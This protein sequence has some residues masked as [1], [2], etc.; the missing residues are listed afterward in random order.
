MAPL[1]QGCC[2]SSFGPWGV[3][4]E[5]PERPSACGFGVDRCHCQNSATFGGPIQCRPVP[6]E[7]LENCARATIVWDAEAVAA[8]RRW[9]PTREAPHHYCR[10]ARRL[11]AIG[12]P[13]SGRSTSQGQKRGKGCIIAAADRASLFHVPQTRSPQ[14]QMQA[15]EIL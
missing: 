11:I 6:E 8:S 7:R 15:P 14:A 10:S 3:S 2:T 4:R 1:T 9:T 13:T 5:L 12:N